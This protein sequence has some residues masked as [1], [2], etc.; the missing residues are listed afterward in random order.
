[1]YNNEILDYLFVKNHTN[2]TT[3]MHQ[4]KNNSAS[5]PCDKEQDHDDHT[6]KVAK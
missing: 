1:M 6:Q 5:P 4:E 3:M 2:N